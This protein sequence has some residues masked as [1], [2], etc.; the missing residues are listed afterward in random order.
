[1]IFPGALAKFFSDFLKPRRRSGLEND[2]VS[3]AAVFETVDGGVD[4]RECEF[5]NEW[6]DL[7][8][9]TEFEHADDSGRTAKRGTREGPLPHD[10][11]EGCECDRLWNGANR[12]EAAFGS[13]RG[14]VTHPIERDGDC[15]DDEIE[16]VG[17]G[18]HSLRIAGIHNAV[19][20]ELFEFLGFV[21]GRSEGGD[22]AAPFIE[23]LHG[24]V[25]EASD[26]ND[27][28]AICG[29]DSEFNDGAE[30]CDAAAEERT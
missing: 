7:M 18:F 26:A 15:A 23:K 12:V 14:D 13:E 25:T 19:G 30:D 11:R 3:W 27:P 9:G 24:E 17:F 4:I 5:L 8:A 1:M 28:N 10:E 2:A 6:C 22:F 16:S 20:T 21:G 29:P